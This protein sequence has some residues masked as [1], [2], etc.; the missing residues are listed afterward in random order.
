MDKRD[1]MKEFVME[2]ASEIKLSDF[3][4][5]ESLFNVK[6]MKINYNFRKLLIR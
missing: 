2:V 6:V 4:G 5:I 3:D 1:C